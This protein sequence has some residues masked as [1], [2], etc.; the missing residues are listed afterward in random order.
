MVYIANKKRIVHIYSYLYDSTKVTEIYDINS[1]KAW[2]SGPSE[3][4]L[5]DNL[6]HCMYVMNIIFVCVLSLLYVIIIYKLLIQ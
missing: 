2:Q 4:S 6:Q 1:A 3:I 5:E